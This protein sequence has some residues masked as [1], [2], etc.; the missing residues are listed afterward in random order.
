M[1]SSALKVRT[2]PEAKTWC[3]LAPRPLVFTNGVFDLLH[4]GHVA[5]LEAARAEGEAL[6]VGI[7]TDRSTRALQKGPGR[8]LV[9]EHDRARTVAAL[10]CVDCV[11]LFDEET[12]EQLIHL[13]RPDVLVKGGDWNANDLPGSAF[14]RAQGGRVVIVPRVAGVST[15]E[16]LERARETI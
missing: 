10:E 12:P 1:T 16:L 9:L 5:V 14:V 3:V 8:P 15:T 7:N 6:L 2:Q 4:A 13:C 11:V